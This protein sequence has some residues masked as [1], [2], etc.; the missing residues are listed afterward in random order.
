MIGLRA[1]ERRGCVSVA[2]LP[3][4]PLRVNADYD[5]SMKTTSTAPTAANTSSGAFSML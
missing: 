1:R 4:S 5:F 3:G 2:R